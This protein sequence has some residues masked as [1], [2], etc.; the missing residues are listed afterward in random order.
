M[1]HEKLNFSYRIVHFS[2]PWW[3]ALRWGKLF[4]KDM[5][6][7]GSNCSRRSNS[8]SNHW[9]IH[10]CNSWYRWALR[11]IVFWLQQPRDHVLHHFQLFQPFWS[12]WR[13][14]NSKLRSQKI[15]KESLHFD[16]RTNGFLFYYRTGIQMLGSVERRWP[17]L[18]LHRTQRPHRLWMLRWPHHQKGRHLPQRGREQL[19]K[20]PRATQIRHEADTSFQVLWK[21]ATNMVNLST[22]T[23]QKA[24]GYGLAPMEGK[25]NEQF[26]W[27]RCC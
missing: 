13:Y 22:S 6:N 19:W 12:L 2:D 11:Q 18:H 21:P 24:K 9:R 1:T 23:R 14:V 26:H 3:I 25:G 15:A 10:W 8:V 20:E 17:H 5:D 27:Q 4:R 16:Y 7:S